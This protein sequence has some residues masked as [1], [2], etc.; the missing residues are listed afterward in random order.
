LLRLRWLSAALLPAMPGTLLEMW[1]RLL[2][3]EW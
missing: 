1:C 2:G 3:R